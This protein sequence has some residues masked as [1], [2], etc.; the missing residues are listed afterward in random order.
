M[1]SVASP[2]VSTPPLVRPGRCWRTLCSAARPQAAQCSAAAWELR[3]HRGYVPDAVQVSKLLAQAFVGGAAEEDDGAALSGASLLKYQLKL[4]AALQWTATTLGSSLITVTAT[5]AESG[6]LA[7]VANVSPGLTG[8]MADAAEQIKLEPG[9]AAATIS[10]MAVSARCRRRG[11]GRALLAACEAAAAQRLTPPA[12]LLAL[13]VYRSNEPAVALYESSGFELDPSWV[14][15]RW[16]ESAERGRQRRFEFGGP[17]PTAVTLLCREPPEAQAGK[18][19]TWQLAGPAAPPAGK[20]NEQSVGSGGARG[21]GSCAAA[22]PA[23]ATHPDLIGLDIWPA[24]IAL[25]RYLSAHRQLV[26]GQAVL[27]VGAGVGLVGLLCAQLGAGSVLLTDNEPA[28]LSLLEGNAALNGQQA[29]CAVLRLDWRRPEAALAAEQRAT[30]RLV[31]AVDVL[32]T[33]AVAEPLLDTLLLALHPEGVALVGHQVRRAIVL[34][35][36]TRLPRLE[37][38]DEPLE[39]FQA[40]A[41]AAGLEV[42]VLGSRETCNV[43][44]DPMV[45]L[46]LGRSA[47]AVAALPAAQG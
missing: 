21:S 16:A 46:A 28:V 34:D 45:L 15:P 26:A 43:D 24:S 38:A 6:E 23:P 7:G 17:Q 37:E 36:A 14:D 4:L 20:P 32:Y 8:V 22:A 19:L 42:R 5:D 30:W 29:R 18:T 1:A 27:E 10:N 2:P 35:P 9:Q 12:S 13:A 31:V 33:S 25:G 39:R 41:A 44:C 40:A 11:L 3:E 47:A